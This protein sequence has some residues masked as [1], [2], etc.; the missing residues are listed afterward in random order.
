MSISNG[1]IVAPVSLADV[2]TV[3]GCRVPSS[4]RNIG[5]V[6]TYNNA[7]HINKWAKFKPV[8]YND[9]PFVSSPKHS[10]Y[11]DKW[12]RARYGSGGGYN[13]DCG[14]TPN[15]RVGGGNRAAFV[16]AITAL[17]SARDWDYKYPTGAMKEPLRLTDFAGYNPFATCPL[18]SLPEKQEVILYTATSSTVSF[19]I[20]WTY[21]ISADATDGDILSLGDIGFDGGDSEDNLSKWYF[22]VVLYNPDNPSDFIMVTAAD[23]GSRFIRLTLNEGIAINHY[24]ALPFV[25]NQKIVYG[26][27]TQSSETY[28]AIPQE[29]PLEI[30]YKTYSNIV[31]AVPVALLVDSSS[32]TVR[33]NINFLNDSN[34]AVTF[35]SITINTLPGLSTS[36][37][38][39][40]GAL[41]D[42]TVAAHTT[43]TVNGTFTLNAQDSCI[44]VLCTAK[45]I[46][47]KTSIINNTVM[48][49]RSADSL[50]DDYIK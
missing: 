16:K 47:G 38:H 40:I 26:N 48:I 45:S 36:A 11:N 10:T 23:A 41:S 19:Q 18:G 5:D 9:L 33:Y 31:D 20:P 2:Y 17:A 35:Q 39:Y 24:M 32:R 8:C 43:T 30:E 37:G 49:M 21:S 3:T 4:G 15:T 34:S 28:I 6:I 22:G 14:L 50:P 1:K 46:T 25:C 42:V 12:W 29:N 7:R 27:P 44:Q 13:G